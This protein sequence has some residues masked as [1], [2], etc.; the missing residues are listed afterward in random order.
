MK[1]QLKT[2]LFVLFV[3]FSMTFTFFSCKA[4]VEEPEPTYYTVTY[5][6]EHGTAPEA[7]SVL[8]NAVL[9]EGQLAALSDGTLVFKGWYDGDV[10]AVAGE[11]KMTGNVTLTAHWGTQATVSYY[12]VLGTV[13]N[14]FDVNP[15]QKLNSGKLAN[16][17]C[18][19][20]KFQGWFYSKDENK[21]GT[22]TKAKVNDP[23]T[24][25]ITLYAKWE[26]ATVTFDT[27]FGSVPSLTKYTGEKLSESEIKSL[28]KSGYTFEGWYNG[29]TQLTSDYT[30]TANVTF[31]AKWTGNPCTLTLKANGGSGD[32]IVKT[33]NYG[34][35]VSLNE[36]TFSYPGY[37]IYKWTKSPDGKGTAY[38]V[39]DGYTVT[40]PKDITLYAQWDPIADEFNIVEMIKKM[41]KSATIAAKGTFTN[42]LIREINAAIKTL[43]N[44]VY[45]DLDL[46]HVKGLKELEDAD[47]TDA[48]KNNSFYSCK[49]LSKLILPENVKSIGSNAFYNCYNLTSV[50]IPIGV[51]SISDHTFEKCSKLTSV[52]IPSSVTSIGD[53]AFKYCGLKSVVIPS[54]VKSIGDSAFIFCSHLTSVVIPSSV[55]SISGHTFGY[56]KNLTSV[57]IPGTLKSIGP[58]AFSG[59]TSLMSVDIPKSVTSIGYDAFNNCGLKSVVIPGS[60][61]SIG[62]SAFCEC[63]SLTSVTIEKGVTSIGQGAF[64]DCERLTSVNIPSSVTSI[65]PFL[66]TNDTSLTT[67][68]IPKSVT[69]IGDAAFKNSGLTS[70]VIPSSVK[71]IAGYAFVTSSLKSMTFIDTEIKW[72]TLA[73]AVGP[74]STDPAVNASMFNDPNYYKAYYF[75]NENYKK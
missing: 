16:I 50:N 53:S 11:Y 40:E 5:V 75:Y 21:N 64:E 13:P 55:T 4:E 23:I 42:S 19:P 72:Y 33:V 61:T 24:A 20:Y 8:E 7:I 36:D 46:S 2:Y 70:V 37:V 65:E 59:C 56:C 39:E 68:D 48:G 27:Q 54:S 1:N 31:T 62:S 47:D 74:M 49:N 66:F 32:D 22:G 35:T 58:C 6:S 12:S 57:V 73:G 38:S 26:T 10:K 45:L 51:T 25:D 29:S 9:T 17:S 69:S 44:G 71:F 14:S 43:P 52:D 34:S 3:I 63:H 67:I 41:K 30:I 28:S 18:N 60:V 15:N